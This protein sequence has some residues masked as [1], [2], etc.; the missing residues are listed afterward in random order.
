LS[1]FLSALE[2]RESVPTQPFRDR[3]GRSKAGL[4]LPLL[5]VVVVGGE[6]VVAGDEVV[7]PGDEVVVG[8]R[9]VVLAGGG[10]LLVDP[11]QTFKLA[12]PVMPK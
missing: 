6:E 7:V 9:E 12:L 10:G 1:P 4:T 2:P 11:E 3:K 8:G 5:P